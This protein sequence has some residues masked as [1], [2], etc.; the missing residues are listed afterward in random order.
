MLNP[1]QIEDVYKQFIDHLQEHAHDGI[2]PVN[3]QFLHGLGLLSGL[4]EDHEDPND[5]T[6]YFHVIE[7]AEKVTL[8][9]EQFLIWIIP[10]MDVS[11][12]KTL[13][14]I[15]LAH[16]NN[17]HLEIVFS[18]NGVYNTPHFVLKILQY[19]LADVLETEATLTSF[20]KKDQ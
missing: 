3:L 10:Q 8:F 11:A 6:Q 20:E 18:T 4:Q 12:P 16:Q 17:P 2:I 9:N 15:A 13:V 14:L 1:T 7:S 5:L 19:F